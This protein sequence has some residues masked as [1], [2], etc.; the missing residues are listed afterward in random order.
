MRLGTIA[1]RDAL[2]Q[3]VPGITD[4]DIQEALWH[5]YYDLDKSVN[6][7]L[8]KAMPK[9]E[10]KKKTKGGSLFPEF[11]T[12]VQM[13]RHAGAVGSQGPDTRGFGG[14]SPPPMV[15]FYTAAAN[16]CTAPQYME[17]EIAL[18]PISCEKPFVMADFWKE[19]QWFNIPEERRTTFVEPLYPRGGLLGGNP[20]APPKMSKL[21]AL[22]AARKKKAE[23]QKKA[24]SQE[25]IAKPM[26]SLTLSS[27]VNTER[28]VS[29]S[30]DR[31][32]TPF[33]QHA[34]KENSQ[35]SS[36][37]KR[38]DSSP[39]SKTPRPSTLIVQVETPVEPL[40]EEPFVETAAPSAF[41]MTMFGGDMA[42]SRPTSAATFSLPYGD[43]RI[44]S[45]DAFAGP[46][47]DDVVKAAQSKGAAARNG[48]L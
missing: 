38:K 18:P 47:P 3:D 34:G 29:G 32:E 36:G 41:A 22:A 8:Q 25:E 39:H 16:A 28:S 33:P 10:K 2:G 11:I 27:S 42:S 30:S 45:T 40:M 48:H 4:K 12:R 14:A 26:A 20:D 21:Q 46:S 1:V 6:Y 35:S 37:L 44:Q 7:L 5:Y 9:E 17:E 13:G 15:P 24:S 43:V 19:I 23:E 31:R